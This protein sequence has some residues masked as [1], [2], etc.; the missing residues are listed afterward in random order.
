MEAINIKN[1]TFKYPKSDNII[2]DTEKLSVKKGAITCLCG[3]SGC[4]KTT[5]LRHLKPSL[6]PRGKKEGYIELMG[7]R[8]DEITAREEPTLIGYVFQNPDNQIV[9]DK[10]WHELCFGLEN[11]AT[12]QDSIR[13]KTA[14]IASFFGIQ[15]WFHKKVSQLSGGQKQ[16]LNLASVMAMQPE[17]LILDEPTSQ[18]DPISASEFFDVI[19]KI[20]TDLGTTILMTEH[21]LEEVIPMADQLVVMREG[22]VIHDGKP[23]DVVRQLGRDKNE[24][25]PAMPA[26]AQIFNIMEEH[27]ADNNS[28]NFYPLNVREGRQWLE[29]FMSDHPS[30]DID[31]GSELYKDKEKILKESDNVVSENL[32]AVQVNEGKTIEIKDIWF[33]YEKNSKDILKGVNMSIYSGEILAIVGGNGTGKSTLLSAINQ[34]RKPFRGKIKYKKGKSIVTLPQN[35]QSF[36]T[37]ETVLDEMMEVIKDDKTIGKEIAN[38]KAQEMIEQMELSHLVAHHPY[39]ISGGEQQRLAIGKVLLKNPDIIL[40]DEPTKGLDISLKGKLGDIFGNLKSQGKTLVI[41][42]HDMDFCSRYADRCVLFFDGNVNSEGDPVKFFAGNNF[43][44]TTTN[45]M[46]RKYFPTAILPED[47]LLEFFQR[48]NV[49][50]KNV[51]MKLDR[52]EDGYEDENSHRKFKKDKNSRTYVSGNAERNLNRERDL[53]R[54]GFH[55]KPLIRNKLYLSILALLGALIFIGHE[56]GGDR[57]YYIVSSIVILIFMLPF[58]VKFEGKGLDI[59]VIV[60]LSVLIALGVAGRQAFF[61]MPQVKPVLAVSIVAGISFGAAEGFITGAMIAFVSNFFFGQGPWTPWQM[62]AMGMAGLIAGIIFKSYR[63]KATP[64]MKERLLVS[65]FGLASGYIYG[66]IVDLWTL[67]AYTESPSFGAY[68]IVKS[69]AVWYDSVLAISTFVFLWLIYE[70]M[71]HKLN[72][73]KLKYDL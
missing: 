59:K 56:Y 5:L 46:C 36:F 41:V 7:K 72:R 51:E 67:F 37:E 60:I 54:D 44:T 23:R 2:L 39:D 10:V 71:V 64:N 29:E 19:R 73:V 14:E 50:I 18:L 9:T 8:D 15:E 57:T 66:L 4:G 25:F 27:F 1:L 31:C 26:P 58:F 49:E 62:L 20:N 63:D 21:R 48:N 42:S 13:L 52:G 53:E 45:R 35:P 65:T 40:L 68:L 30:C 12:D 32:Q 69:T 38:H 24:I 34:S 17:I 61:M 6:R 28:Q 43:Y 11:I 47:V 70:P 55:K 3:P 16:I 33:R 22:K